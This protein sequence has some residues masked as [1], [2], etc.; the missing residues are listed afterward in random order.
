MVG[1]GEGSGT[2]MRE[3]VHLLGMKFKENNKSGHQLQKK[4]SFVLKEKCLL[5][6]RLLHTS[7][8]LEM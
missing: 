8:T 1:G 3:F 2:S 4:M 6:R 7:V 5:G